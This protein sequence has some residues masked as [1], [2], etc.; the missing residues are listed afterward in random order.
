MIKNY[1]KQQNLKSSQTVNRIIKESSG[2]L[3]HQSD[4][5]LFLQFCVKINYIFQNNELSMIANEF[6]EFDNYIIQFPV[7]YFRNISLISQNNI[8]IIFFDCLQTNK[9][10]VIMHSCISLLNDILFCCQDSSQ[11]FCNEDFLHQLVE[12]I[13]SSKNNIRNECIKALSNI[14]LESDN[15]LHEYILS[16]LPLEKFI[17]IMKSNE[18]DKNLIENS[19]NYFNAITSFP[20]TLQIDHDILFLANEYFS[21]FPIRCLKIYKNLVE[22]YN[23]YDGFNY[24]RM[25]DIL[26]VEAEIDNNLI[27][28]CCDFIHVLLNHNPDI[29]AAFDVEKIA[30][31]ALIPIDSEYYNETLK[32]N[33]LLVLHDIGIYSRYIQ[34]L[35]IQFNDLSNDCKIASGYI[36][37]DFA[38]AVNSHTASLLVT[39]ESN[40]FSVARNLLNLYI[41][42]K[43]LMINIFKSM[44]HF[45]EV[46]QFSQSTIEMFSDEFPGDTIWHFIETDD[47]EVRQVAMAFQ[48][49]CLTDEEET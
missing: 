4:D 49:A 19:L 11:L 15:E 23:I 39:D 44:Q 35:M 21:I 2:D 31:F 37:F 45:F 5:D 36:I 27:I 16:L 18:K 48:Q 34:T 41:N 20:I 40:I 38:Q 42:F 24:Q 17:L 7:N 13:M 1:K 12:N 22:N 46:T 10:Y 3:N 6:I 43:N 28:E 32:Y 30:F 9:P 33:A 47:D 8:P 26:S 29:K 25:N 14:L